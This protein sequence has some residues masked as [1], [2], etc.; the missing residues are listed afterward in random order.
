MDFLQKE[1]RLVQSG[2]RVFALGLTWMTPEEGR[3]AKKAASSLLRASDLPIDLVLYRRDPIEQFAIG[4]TQNSL[5]PNVYSAAGIVAD[6]F[7]ESWL[8]A[9]RVA[10]GIWICAGRDDRVLPHGDTFYSSEDEARA[11][12]DEFLQETGWTDVY[13]PETWGTQFEEITFDEISAASP[14]RWTKLDSTSQVK[15]AI[16]IAIPV[17]IMGV[18]GALVYVFFFQPDPVT[19]PTSIDPEKRRE[20][21]IRAR[22]KQREE[23]FARLDA[24]APWARERD[25]DAFIATCLDSMGKIPV[26]PVSF[27]TTSVRCGEP[28][29]VG[30]RTGGDFRPD[31]VAYAV[32]EKTDDGYIRWLREWHEDRREDFRLEFKMDGTRAFLSAAVEDVREAGG[33]GYET[34]P[35]ETAV[36]SR[37]YELAQIEESSIGFGER[38]V[39]GSQDY[40]SYNPKYAF[41]S[42]SIETS[43]PHAWRNELDNLPGFRVSEISLDPSNLNYTLKGTLYVNDE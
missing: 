29:A 26:D 19:N 27:E 10:D 4:S 17:S 37:F 41:F 32:L 2:R 24:R 40:P 18:I 35:L 42:V 13:A 14:R 34:L 7:E 3:S 22:E 9:V 33:G 23:A 28:G 1:A 43:R 39:L 5:R 38:R 6:S 16:N 25:P 31:L 11:A 30:A 36:K 21:L 20:A 15:K 12:F 8:M